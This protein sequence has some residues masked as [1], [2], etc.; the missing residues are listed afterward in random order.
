MHHSTT[1]VA[2]LVLVMNASLAFA[3]HPSNM[4][5]APR[6]AVLERANKSA[7]ALHQAPYQLDV[8]ILSTERKSVPGGHTNVWQRVR[9]DAC[10]RGG[11][12]KVGDELAVV[13]HIYFN[14]PRTPGSAGDRGP[15]KGE[16]GLPL[17]GDRARIFAE[18]SK[19]I[20]RPLPPNG[21]QACVATAS[22]DEATLGALPTNWKIATTHADG[23]DASWKI[24]VDAKVQPPA[25]LLSLVAPNHT[26]PGAYNLCWTNA[27]TIVDGIIEVKM[28]ANLGEID[29]GGGLVWRALDANNYYLARY[30]PLEENYRVYVVKDGK[31]T[32][33]ASAEDTKIAPNACC[34]LQ[35]MHV[36]EKIECWLDGK[37]LLEARDN[38]LPARGGVG[39]WT[40]A[41]A[42]SSF[43]EFVVVEASE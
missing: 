25:R 8:T 12:V 3:S 21:W 9:I 4:S 22:F 40:K 10:M 33:L 32:Q 18:G 43:G 20:L 41:D 5:R 35:I 6:V 2:A 15:F 30:N 42:A 29:Q 31:R 14:P 26:A 37:R 39:V 16:N 7:W 38:T 1:I 11:D 17:D 19:E 13:S 27:T 24:E 36:G 28:R 23:S 34:T